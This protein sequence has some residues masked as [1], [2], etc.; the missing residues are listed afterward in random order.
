VTTP[1][2]DV[3]RDI[4][5][6]VV[7]PV[8]NEEENLPLLRDALLPAVRRYFPRCELVVV[9]DGSTDGTAGRLDAL[10][11]STPRARRVTHAARLGYPRALL[12]GLR[13]ARGSWVFYTDA[14]LPFHAVEF[15]KA[16]PLTHAADAVFGYRVDYDAPWKRRF[17]TSACSLLTRTIL[18]VPVRDANFAF[19]LIRRSAVTAILP[20]LHARSALIGAEIAL[21]VRRSGFRHA[22]VAVR[23]SPRRF[24]VSKLGTWKWAFRAFA[25]L[26]RCAATGRF[27]RRPS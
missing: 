8:F 9:D 2:G 27:R 3:I 10:E 11:R 18:G 13:A 24:G 4:D 14:D 7:V 12:S 1:G 15:R 6:S 26:L 16:V 20:R 19:K 21:A 23:Y 5:L 25:D 17:F 22:E